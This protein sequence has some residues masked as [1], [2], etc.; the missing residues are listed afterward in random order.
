LHSGRVEKITFAE[1][2][3]KQ[4]S[5]RMSK[6]LTISS[7]AAVSLTLLWACA[8]APSECVEAPNVAGSLAPMPWQPLHQ[9]VAALSSQQQVV[10]FFSQH[11]ALRDGFFSRAAYP[12]D[13]S[14]INQ[15]Y[16]RF[17]H[18]AFDSLLMETEKV[19]GDGE[20]LRAQFQEAFTRMKYHYPEFR[21]PKVQ[22][23]I[24]GLESDVW[25]SDTLVVV[26]LDY[27]LGPE[28]RYRPH[29]YDYILQRYTK[30]FVVPA[31]LLLYGIGPT[32]NKVNLAD[33]TVLA[34]MI[35]YGKAYYF[36]KQML[37]CV[38]DSVLMGYTRE[39]MEGSRRYENLIWSRLVEDEVLYSTSHLVRQKYIAERPK[40]LEV[41]EKC[42]GRIG[43]WVGWQ[44]VKKYADIHADTP[45][46]ELMMAADAEKLFR[47]SGYKPQVMA[48]GKQ[49]F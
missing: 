25:V 2:A 49:K 21:I 43:A 34:D 9:Q 33:K 35:A 46:H 27:F 24:S 20:E 29:I 19:F 16:Q 48:L 32:Y 31:V 5:S 23:I 42:P 22:T 36:A 6:I 30:D 37:P 7:T 38:P 15:L 14:F 11:T 45:L 40:T 13:S 4:T 44:I 26:S 28:A 47:E 41:G 3:E 17:S 18:P 10:D 39:E 8:S 12:S 1:I